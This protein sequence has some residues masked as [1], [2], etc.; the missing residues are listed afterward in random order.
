MNVP[1]L[2]EGGTLALPDR[3]EV[4]FRRHRHPDPDAPTILLLHGWTASAD[5]QFFSA[6]EALAQRCSFVGIDHRG[7][8]RGMRTPDPFTLE[9]C[10][11][12]AAQLVQALGIGQVILIGYSMG[13]PISLLLARRHPELVRAIVVQATAMTFATSF[14]D[15]LR[16][17]TV[18][19]VGP[20][21][22]SWA[23]PR[24]V[25]YALRKLLGDG[26]PFKRY[27]GWLAGE[28]NRNDALA[29][30]Q[31]G[32]ELSTFD[33]TPWTGILGKPAGSL[34]TTGDHLVPPRR[35]R[36]LA[37]ALGATVAEVHADHL[38]ALVA[39]DAYVAATMSLLDRLT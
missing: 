15:R 16:W 1:W 21:V 27:A 22:R 31:A 36:A 12:D 26:H 4:F 14:V 24:S 2:P 3:G 25:R 9:D 30:V 13:G 35:Q 20:L 39:P 7:H 6:Y 18:R 37:A 34:I 23:F 33:A 8:G 11:E 17:R 28:V 32:R 38:A 5:L 19:L 29:L 10:A